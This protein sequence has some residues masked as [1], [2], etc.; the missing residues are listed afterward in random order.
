VDILR[1]I[2]LPDWGERSNWF[3]YNSALLADEFLIAFC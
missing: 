3:D 2:R 1:S